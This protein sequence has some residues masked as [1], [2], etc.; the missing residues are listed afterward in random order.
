MI[1]S[2][3]TSLLLCPG[4]DLNSRCNRPILT[5]F[6]VKEGVIGAMIFALA[7]AMVLCTSVRA[8]PASPANLRV[9]YS[10][11]IAGQLT[12]SFSANGTHKCQSITDIG[13]S[14]AVSGNDFNDCHEA[15]V[16]LQMNDCCPST[17]TCSLNPNGT[18]SCRLG[19]SSIE[20]TMGA[21]IPH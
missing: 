5:D 19:G 3:I 7:A 14:C 2:V 9:S 12:P 15:A 1:I 21:C 8:E 11:L 16:K 10:I 20:F 17:R 18:Q 4:A 13:H 6:P